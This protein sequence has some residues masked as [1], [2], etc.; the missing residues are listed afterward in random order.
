MP[1]L[2]SKITL[3]FVFCF[4]LSS[5]AQCQQKKEIW[6]AIEKQ[7]SLIKSAKI[8]WQGSILSFPEKNYDLQQAKV[9]IAQQAR[10]Q[11]LPPE[12]V[13]QWEAA[14]V[15][16]IQS[17]IL[18]SEQKFEK[19]FVVE[20]PRVKGEVMWAAKTDL[21]GVVQKGFAASRD[22]DYFDGKNLVEMRGGAKSETDYP[23]RGVVSKNSSLQMQYT[24]FRFGDAQFLFGAPLSQIVKE[25]NMD[26]VTSQEV[27]FR[28]KAPETSS[29]KGL[30]VTIFVS[31]QYRRLTSLEVRSPDGF[32][33]FRQKATDWKQYADGIWF[34]NKIV[35]TLFT[36]ESKLA[37]KEELSLT[38]AAW[39]ASA[40]LNE[41]RPTVVVPK[42]TVLD[43]LRFT[44]RRPIRYKVRKQLP[45]DES[46]LR[47]IEEHE[48]KDVQGERQ[49][50]LTT[51][52]NIALPVGAL[53][54]IGGLIW[55]RRSRQ[56]ST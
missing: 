9:N 5:L 38:A 14:A 53:L 18:G 47:M 35:A 32:L 17:Q 48:K 49:Q 44:P 56:T 46:V 10:K 25:G 13:K 19:T 6:Q 15:Q 20:W 26:Q 22:V 33:F 8:T 36:G 4:S 30:P 29:W 24:A 41:L 37:V 42:G 12:A 40:D 31:R 2:L 7:D 45:P 39:N 23:Q 21:Q 52:R 43:D 55:W 27:I 16:A 54:F 51:V 11:N 50:Q 34:P 28:L 3:C 1:S